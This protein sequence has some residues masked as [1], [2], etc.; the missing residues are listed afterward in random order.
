MAAAS[1]NDSRVTEAVAA[2]A[3]AVGDT[4]G[5]YRLLRQLGEGTAGT[6]FE[7]EHLRIGRRAAMKIVHP[8]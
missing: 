1:I 6:V 7:V 8:N 2:R 4:I 3:P 5:P